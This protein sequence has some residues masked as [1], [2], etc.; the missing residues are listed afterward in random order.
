MTAITAEHKEVKKKRG[1]KL[2]MWIGLR[3]FPLNQLEP[4][5]D[6][7]SMINILL[8]GWHSHLDFILVLIREATDESSVVLGVHRFRNCGDCRLIVIDVALDVRAITAEGFILFI[9]NVGPWIGFPL[10]SE[11]WVIVG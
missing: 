5:A 11:Y 8:P 6:V 2:K 9:P 3:Y 1:A 4:D 10:H 7:Q